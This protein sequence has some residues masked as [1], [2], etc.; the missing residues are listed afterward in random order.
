MSDDLGIPREQRVS[1]VMAMARLAR[2]KPVDAADVSPQDWRD[3]APAD[4]AAEQKPT[5]VFASV[6]GHA[7]AEIDRRPAA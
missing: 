1:P 6:N 7:Q 4:P 5:A 3:H 2:A